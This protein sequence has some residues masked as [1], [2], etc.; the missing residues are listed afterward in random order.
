MIAK[1]KTIT[2]IGYDLSDGIVFVDLL[3]T[4]AP[5]A[6]AS[7]VAQQTGANVRKQKLQRVALVIEHMKAENIEVCSHVGKMSSLH[8]QHA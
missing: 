1:S 6:I 7:T 2:D 5:R 4:M 3:Q 8:A